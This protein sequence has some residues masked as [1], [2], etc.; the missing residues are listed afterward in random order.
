MLTLSAMDSDANSFDEQLRFAEENDV[1]QAEG[2]AREVSS[3]ISNWKTFT[4]EA[5]VLES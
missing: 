1:S 2:V 5:Q 4:V 3:A